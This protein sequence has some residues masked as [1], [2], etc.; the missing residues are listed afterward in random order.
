MHILDQAGRM[1]SD[2]PDL[3]TH[4]R[5]VAL[6]ALNAAKALRFSEP[7]EFA[8][9][10]YMHDL[11]K[12]TWP[13]ELFVKS[14]LTE[15]DRS[16]IRIHPI[17]GEN[18]VVQTWPD[19]PDRIKSL[20]RYHHER[21]GGRGYPDGLTDP[22]VEI[23]LLS[24]CDVFDAMTTARPY[25]KNGEALSVEE[26]LFEVARFAPAQVVAALATAVLKKGA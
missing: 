16:I 15:H 10:G 13:P 7:E 21:P 3:E 6:L 5:G 17:V 18:L 22:G 20:I 19:V 23:L 9:A 11:G 8:I 1:L 24:A 2:Y 14:P 26:A 25:R 4:S 12:T